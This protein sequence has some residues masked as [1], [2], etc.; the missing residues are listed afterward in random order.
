MLLLIVAFVGWTLTRV[1]APGFRVTSVGFL[2]PEDN[3][4]HWH[5]SEVNVSFT[6]GGFDEPHQRIGHAFLRVDVTTVPAGSALEVNGVKPPT[7]VMQSEPNE[8]HYDLN[9]N[10]ESDDVRV[11]QDSNNRGIVY[12]LWRHQFKRVTIFL[13]LDVEPTKTTF[14]DRQLYFSYDFGN[15]D[16][17]R[18]T[19][20][21]DRS[22]LNRAGEKLIPYTVHCDLRDADSPVFDYG[23]PTDRLSA[24]VSES[25]IVR[26]SWRSERRE[27]LRDVLLLV[28][29]TLAAFGAAAILE[30][31]RPYVDA[32]RKY[33][34]IDQSEG[35]SPD[36]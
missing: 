13:P 18:D 12:T 30:G 26:L 19:L 2:R 16:K 23:T 21:K 15:V 9:G 25:D 33:S 22:L 14:A 28:L 35:D 1:Q 11:W 34:Q 3:R 20:D 24:R 36:V 7:A 6:D 8:D 17:Y 5:T 31:V 32:F 4:P 29:G 10:L 27:Q